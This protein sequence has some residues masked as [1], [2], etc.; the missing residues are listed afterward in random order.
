MHPHFN[1]FLPNFNQLRVF[2]TFL[3]T[4]A[5]SN[6]MNLVTK[7]KQSPDFVIIGPTA[8]ETTPNPRKESL[9]VAPM[10]LRHVMSAPMSVGRRQTVKNGLVARCAACY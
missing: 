1:T 9:R 6:K 4:Y 2:P 8:L 7:P 3:R 5:G 10:R